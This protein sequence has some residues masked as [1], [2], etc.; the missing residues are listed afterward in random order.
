MDRIQVFLLVAGAFLV[1]FLLKRVFSETGGA[2]ERR[3]A[4]E[5]LDAEARRDVAEASLEH[6]CPLCGSPCTFHRYPHIEVW[7][8][9]KFPSCR[10]FL[11]A[12][13][14]RRPGFAVKWEQGRG[15][16]LAR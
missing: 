3:R 9:S 2:S 15:K 8:C 13:K 10:G 5:K 7:R 11:P 12:R 14:T 16:K 4:L 6:S 1:L